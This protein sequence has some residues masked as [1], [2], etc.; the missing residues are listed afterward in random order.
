MTREGG[1]ADLSA[2]LRP[3]EEQ[4]LAPPAAKLLPKVAEHWRGGRRQDTES[5]PRAGSGPDRDHGAGA[6]CLSARGVSYVTRIIRDDFIMLTFLVLRM[7]AECLRGH[8]T[9]YLSN[10]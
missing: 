7:K 6:F 2:A 1:A 3:A 4:S 5:E 10:I 9:K 8:E